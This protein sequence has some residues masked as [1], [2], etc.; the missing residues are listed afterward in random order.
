[1]TREAP[2]QQGNSTREDIEKATMSDSSANSDR[3]QLHCIVHHRSDR[4]ERFSVFLLKDCMFL[5][6]VSGGDWKC[7]RV[8]MFARM[9]LVSK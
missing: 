9:L 5:T 1:M 2:K 3:R 6:I 8:S 4:L 7:F